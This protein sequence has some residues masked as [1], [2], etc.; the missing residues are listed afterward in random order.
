MSC[1]SVIW[2]SKNQIEVYKEYAR[3]ET[4]TLINHGINLPSIDEFIKVN[5]KD[6]WK[7][8]LGY[9]SDDILILHLGRIVRMKGQIYTIEAYSLLKVKHPEISKKVKCLMVGAQYLTSENIAYLEEVKAAAEKKHLNVSVIKNSTGILD[10][11]FFYK[12]TYIEPR[13][14]FSTLMSSWRLSSRL[15][16]P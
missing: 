4:S 7:A 12:N 14:I 16:Q 10:F 9:N 15:L 3:K 13:I 5:T 1:D 8:V 11:D 6:Q 2:I